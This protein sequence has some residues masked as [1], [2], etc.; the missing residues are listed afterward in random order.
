MP[1]AQGEARAARPPFS[2]VIALLTVSAVWEARLDAALRDHGLTTRKYGLLAHIRATP[3]ISFSELARRSQ[4]T[5]QSAHTAVR[6]LV[7][8]GLVAD[9]TA[10]AGA[11]SDLRATPAGDAVLARADA[12]LA[13]LDSEFGGGAPR[14][15]A[16][17][18]GLHEEPFT[19]GA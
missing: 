15:T 3:G 8:A 17:L 12:H 7:D 5:V 1:D 10:Q 6:A 11:A 19:G 14:L 4:I 2:P 18:E 16:A 9:S 13:A